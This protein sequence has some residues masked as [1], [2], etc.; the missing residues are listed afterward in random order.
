MDATLAQAFPDRAALLAAWAAQPQVGSPLIAVHLDVCNFDIIN[1]LCGA[2]ASGDFLTRLGEALRVQ[3]PAGAKIAQLWSDEFALLFRASSPADA[4]AEVERLRGALG[5][6]PLPD[7]AGD[8]PFRASYGVVIAAVDD[9]DSALTRAQFACR[10]AR[11]Q[12]TNQIHMYFD[13]GGEATIR[14]QVQIGATMMRMIRERELVL[15]AQPIVRIDE[16]GRN[17]VSKVEILLRRKTA[18]GAVP[19][20]QGFLETA[21]RFGFVRVLDEFVLDEA[22]HWFREHKDVLAQLDRI[23]I[24]LSGHT[25]SDRGFHDQLIQKVHLGGVPPEKLC[26]E[27]T[28]TSLVGNLAQVKTLI[29]ELKALGCSVALDDFGI[30]L[31]SFGYLMELP[32][33][34]VKIDGSFVKRMRDDPSA[35]KIVEALQAVAAATGKRTLAEFVEDEETYGMLRK[36]GVQYAQGWLFAK[37]IPLE[38]LKAFIHE[39]N[40]A[41]LNRTGSAG[42]ESTGPLL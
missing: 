2:Q 1:L 19:V 25:L 3:A 8:L 39:H 34:E 14:A 9:A 36:L 18:K 24:N 21:E 41:A 20:P 12:G 13:D 10:E 15:H 40:S 16:Y 7:A 37:A 22:L 4:I 42:R 5:Q 26:F 23:A 28:E 27:I 17:R 33:D 30:G 35:A 31:C 6:L 11:K 38:Q 29:Q 32:V